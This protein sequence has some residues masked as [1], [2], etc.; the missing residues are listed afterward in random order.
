MGFNYFL[1]SSF[2]SVPL[3]GIW[4]FIVIS[5]LGI[6]VLLNSTLM[7]L[8]IIGRI[9]FIDLFCLSHLCPLSVNVVSVG[10]FEVL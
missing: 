7:R 10:C 4:Y 5:L 1:C 2:F 3:M 6:W 8:W 9:H